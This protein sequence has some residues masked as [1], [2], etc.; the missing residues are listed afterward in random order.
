M[1]RT[2]PPP[3]LRAR[4]LRAGAEFL[5]TRVLVVPV[6]TALVVNLGG[7]A[8]GWRQQR[9]PMRLRGGPSHPCHPTECPSTAT[10][11]APASALLCKAGGLWATHLAH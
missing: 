5:A 8:A 9:G 3:S 1:G 6:V 4:D 2:G 10:C 11:W 7:G